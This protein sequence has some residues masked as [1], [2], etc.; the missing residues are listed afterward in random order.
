MNTINPHDVPPGW[1]LCFNHNCQRREACLRYVTGC[2]LPPKRDWG[3][4]IYPTALKADGQCRWY[5]TAQLQRV[6]WGF[7]HAFD[8]V[9]RYDFKPMRLRITEILGSKGM[10]YEYRNG[11]RPVM[12]DQQEAIAGVFAAFGYEAPTYEEYGSC[13]DYR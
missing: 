4:A 9:R 10:Y 7:A 12:P 11:L 8:K 3:P 6:A 1:Q 13:Y 2:Q 5:R